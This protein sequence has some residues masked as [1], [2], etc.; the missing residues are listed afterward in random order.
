MIVD[1][2]DIVDTSDQGT[3]IKIKQSGNRTGMPAS[4]QAPMVTPRSE[5]YLG[6]IAGNDPAALQELITAGGGF[7]CFMTAAELTNFQSAGSA[8]AGSIPSS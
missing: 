2:F 6:V 7:I 1:R 8:S 3:V 5:W 4:V